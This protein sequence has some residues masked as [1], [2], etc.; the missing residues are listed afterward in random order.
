M[1]YKTREADN[2]A[3]FNLYAFCNGDPVNYIDPNGHA[4]KP[5]AWMDWN[6]DSI[7]DTQRDRNYFDK[8]NDYIAD[9][10]QGIGSKADYGINTAQRQVYNEVI[11]NKGIVSQA[12]I[13][14]L[15]EPALSEIAGSPEK[16][17][18]WAKIA[19]VSLAQMNLDVSSLAIRSLM[20][21]ISSSG[22]IVAIN[23]I[24]EATKDKVIYQ[25]ANNLGITVSEAATIY[26]NEM[27]NGSL[28]TDSNGVFAALEA[29]GVN[30]SEINIVINGQVMKNVTQ[31]NDRNYVDLREAVEALN[32][33]QSGLATISYDGIT[34]SATVSIK[35]LDTNE[36]YVKQFD[37][38]SYDTETDEERG[39]IVRNGTIMVG[40]RWLAEKSGTADLLSWWSERNNTV[41]YG[42][43][44]QDMDKSHVKVT[45]QN[46]EVKIIFY[47]KYQVDPSVAGLKLN[48]EDYKDLADEGFMEWAGTYDLIKEK[49]NPNDT[50]LVTVSVDLR[51]ATAEE[52]KSGQQELII[53]IR[54]VKGGE[55]A[56]DMYNGR[57][58]TYWLDSSKPSAYEMNL[59]IDY[60]DTLQDGYTLIQNGVG[61]AS[62]QGY[63][64]RNRKEFVNLA[65]HEFGHVLGIEDAYLEYTTHDKNNPTII[66]EYR[67]E[68]ITSVLTEGAPLNL[69]PYNST[70]V[71]IMKDNMV[72]YASVTNQNILMV[73]NAFTFNEFQ[74]Y[75]YY[76]KNVYE[77]KYLPVLSVK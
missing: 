65:T 19:G 10:N 70:Q 9:W 43:L 40:L 50:E 45:R 33:Y 17:V 14:G 64:M 37:L 4:T 35:N 38:N 24:N 32:L 42:V 5:P 67:P 2:P 16:V 22:R 28:S 72:L 12:T 55:L 6:D 7:I 73:I 62:Y 47:R 69:S 15:I 74:N 23:G 57:G 36:T 48:G 58:S 53:N 51:S 52:I 59:Y 29:E 25:L 3:T 8:N 18:E 1:E 76:A 75:E 68:L 44:L 39:Y 71:D 34:N 26:A 27:E 66:V 63:F 54:D 77:S 20:P 46:E 49:I 31:E 61:V 56:Q 21:E 11:A 60:A 30:L 13:S 41:S